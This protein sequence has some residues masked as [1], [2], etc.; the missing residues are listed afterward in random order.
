MPQHEDR[1]RRVQVFLFLRQWN[2]VNVMLIGLIVKE[3]P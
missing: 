2:L 1:C 3:V